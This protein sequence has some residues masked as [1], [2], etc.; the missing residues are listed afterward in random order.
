[1]IVAT[2]P[3][4]TVLPPSR[5][6]VREIGVILL[7]L[8]GFFSDFFFDMRLVS[9][10]FQ[11]FV[12]M[13]LSR[14]HF[15]LYCCMPLSFSIFPFQTPQIF[16]G[17]FGVILGQF[18]G[19]WSAIAKI[20][21]LPNSLPVKHLYARLILYFSIFSADISRHPL[22][23]LVT[24]LTIP[25]LKYMDNLLRSYSALMVFSCSSPIFSS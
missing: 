4:P 15:N 19:N 11:I 7:D 25:F 23:S 21:L 8:Q 1:M 13:V 5:F 24:A 3:E 9:D 22:K 20:I 12:I 18:W 2:L 6:S 16:W 14:K 17:S 10:V